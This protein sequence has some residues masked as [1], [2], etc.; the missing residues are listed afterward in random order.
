MNSALYDSYRTL[1]KGTTINGVTLLSTDYLN[2]FNEAVMLLEIVPDM[3]EMLEDVRDW[4]P[5]TYQE[6]FADSQFKMR[7]LAIE[8]YDHSPPEFRQPFDAVVARLNRMVA[9]AVET[10]GQAIAQGDAERLSFLVAEVTTALRGEIDRAGA[11]VNGSADRMA[12]DDVDALFG[13]TGVSSVDGSDSTPVDTPLPEPEPP[14][15]HAKLAAQ[16]AEELS[17]DVPYEVA[18]AFSR[19][20]AAILG[21]EERYPLQGRC[22]ARN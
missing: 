12:Q 11:I 9:E 14:L 6:H 10:V 13:S 4:Q 1:A 21:S 7:D 3:P 16:L 15:G 18:I 17:I 19:G 5:K 2:H 8:A 20:V 22:E